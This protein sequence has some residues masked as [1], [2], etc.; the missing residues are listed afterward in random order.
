M[1][2]I[3]EGGGLLILAGALLLIVSAGFGSGLGK[4]SIAAMCDKRVDFMIE[5]K[6]YRCEE[7]RP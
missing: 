6:I 3:I 1:R 4:Q 7:R 2:K 5:G